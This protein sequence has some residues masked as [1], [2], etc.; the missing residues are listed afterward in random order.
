MCRRVAACFR[1]PSKVVMPLVIGRRVR[2]VIVF[3]TRKLKKNSVKHARE[4][5]VGF[6][7]ALSR[8]IPPC[9]RLRIIIMLRITLTSPLRLLMGPPGW[10]G[11][12]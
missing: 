12:G 5:Y 8:S 11:H 2:A 9:L 1:R 4:I 6:K 10:Q 3:F 7:S